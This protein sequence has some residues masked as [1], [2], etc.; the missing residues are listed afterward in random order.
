MAIS[1]PFILLLMDYY[2][3]RR[4]KIR[5]ILEKIPFIVLT[6][7]FV[8]ITFYSQQT[9]ITHRIIFLFPDNFL[10]LCYRVVFYLEKLAV[11]VNL[12]CLYPYPEK[13]NG[14]L[15]LIYWFSPLILLVLISFVILILKRL[16]YEKSIIFGIFFILIIMLPVLQ[17]IPVGRAIAAD[18]YTYLSY[19][20]IFFILAKGCFYIFKVKLKNLFPVKLF[21]I[22]IFLCLITI[23]CVLTWHRCLV[24]KGSVTL[25]TDVINKY[26]RVTLAYNNRGMAYLEKKE[27]GLA[28]RDFKQASEIDGNDYVTHTNLCDLYL[29]TGRPDEA[30]ASC[31]RAIALKPDCFEAFNNLGSIYFSSGKNH[32]ALILYKKALEINPDYAPIHNNLSV[33]YYYEKQYDLAVK[34]YKK[35]LALGYKV[36]PEF[37]DLIKPYCSPL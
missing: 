35:A 2:V 16:K 29:K 12:S 21:F 15:P 25:W 26:P 31:K 7:P 23:L 3:L 19:I 10:Y 1:L 27:Y 20:G 34:H 8:I 9:A 14:F 24:W 28:A 37:S 4:S 33:I 17:I 30:F 18:R 5:I 32:E 6:I 36:Y 13:I 11:P 22:C